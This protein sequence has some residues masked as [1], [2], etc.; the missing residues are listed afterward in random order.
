MAR[1][2]FKTLWQDLTVSWQDL[3]ELMARSCYVITG[4]WQLDLT[5]S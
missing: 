2:F 4:S 1:T 3:V 5:E